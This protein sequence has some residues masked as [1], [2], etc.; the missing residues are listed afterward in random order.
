M[1]LAPLAVS[2][3]N[4]EERQPSATA[5][6]VREPNRRIEQ[7][8]L[9]LPDARKGFQT[10]LVRREAEKEP[11][12]DP[13]AQLLRI[14]R[15]EAPVGKLPAYLTPDPQDGKKHPA[16]IWITGGVCNTIGDVWS[17]APASNDQ[18]AAAYRKAGIVMMFPSLRGGNDNP[19][20][21]EGFLGEVDD[22]LAA[23]DFLAK[24]PYVDPD[25]IYLGGHS[26]GGT[27]VLLAAESTNRFRAVISFGPVEDVVG[28]GPQ[29]LPFEITKYREL[30]LRSPL[31]WLASIKS[32][33]FVFEGTVNGNLDS[34]RVLADSSS[35][36]NVQFFEV[37]GANHFNI[38][39]PTNRLIAE[40]ILHDDGPTCNLTFTAEELNTPFA[41]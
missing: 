17:D 14:V 19:G 41:R 23:A 33:T 4:H 12:P 39:A 31:R 38:L 1:L 2:G 10:K 20:D 18:T 15:Y 29:F 3:C 28:Y 27:L 34:L 16:I 25:R 24:Q 26:T 9:S 36:S 22:V 35:E 7:P 32:P 11:V 6:V 37:D 21:I 8:N 5:A 30:E 40:K 13:P